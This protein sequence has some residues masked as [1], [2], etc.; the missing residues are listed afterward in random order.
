MR[1]PLNNGDF[2]KTTAW[3]LKHCVRDHSD[4]SDKDDDMVD[5]YG[6]GVGFSDDDFDY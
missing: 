6:D 2:G 5:Y 4:E 1:G 3:L